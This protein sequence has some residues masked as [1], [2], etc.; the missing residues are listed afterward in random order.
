[1][2]SSVLLEWHYSP[3]SFIEDLSIITVPPFQAAPEQGKIF[4]N[5]SVLTD[6]EAEEEKN[7]LHNRL[8]SLFRTVQLSNHCA[9]E[10]S[11][12]LTVTTDEEGKRKIVLELETAVEVAEAGRLDVLM[13]DPS[14]TVV[15]D[16]RADRV[17]S[18]KAMNEMV[19]VCVEG[20]KTLHFMLESYDKAVRFP[21]QEC[22]YL[23]QIYD[24]LCKRLGTRKAVEAE[25]SGDDKNFEDD[26][27]A[28]RTL[29]CEAPIIQGRHA[30]YS[31][32][33][34]RP[35]TWEEL[36]KV[37]RVAR[38]MVMKYVTY[39]QK[40]QAGGVGDGA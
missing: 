5:I 22:M 13:T 26:I 20:D 29:C 35:A 31:H 8:L 39:L 24:A 18:L 37:R 7:H 16:T 32:K 19:A 33:E 6:E 38:D 34:L 9:F 4:A 15:V 27:E 17:S 1:M 10:L 21:G 14:G 3:A 36:K 40:Q 11:K 28:F 23:Y 2:L 12:P 25:F 30:G